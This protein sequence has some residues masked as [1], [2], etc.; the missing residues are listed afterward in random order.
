MPVLII[1]IDI[2]FIKIKQKVHIFRYVLLGNQGKILCTLLLNY[3]FISIA[4]YAKNDAVLQ[5]SDNLET[6]RL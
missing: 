3:I 5:S 1:L 6:I 4:K 2:I